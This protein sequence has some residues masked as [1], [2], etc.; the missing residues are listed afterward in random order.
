MADTTTI[1]KNP[2]L[3]SEED[4]AFLRSAGLQYIE[5]LGSALWTDY[6]EHDPGITILEALCYAITE[7]GYRAQLPMANLLTESNGQIASSQALFTAKNILTQAPL[8]IDDYRKLLIDIEG[9]HNAWLLTN[10]TKTNPDGT[11]STIAEVPFYA[12]CKEDKLT[13][14]TTPHPIFI[15]G[16]YTVLLDL[17]D[18]P[19]VGS[20]NNGE[21]EVLSPAIT[22]YN[23]G[24]VSFTVIFPAWNDTSIN[25]D[26][27]NA[28]KDAVSNVTATLT[29][30]GKDWKLDVSFSVTK[31]DDTTITYNATLSAE[32]VI[33]LQPSGRVVLLTDMQVFFSTQFTQQVIS[34][35]IYKLQQTK[36]IVQTAIKTLHENRNLCEDFIKVDT[37]P[38]EDIAI[39][40]DIDVTV[41]TDM[42]AVQADVWFA[43]EQYL[44]PSV[45]FYLLKDLLA[46]GYTPDEVF[47]GPRLAHGFIDTAE[48]ENTQL[49]TVIHASDVISLIMDI[50]GVLAVKNFRMTKYDANGKPVAN[51]TSKSWCMNITPGHKPVFY[52]TASKIL[53]YKNNFPCLP[54]LSEVRDTLKWLKAV[55]AA[56]KL[57]SHGDD[58]P[59]PIGQYNSIDEY[60]SI[61]ELFPQTYGIGSAGL[62]SDATEQ[63]KAQARQL[64]AYLLFYDQLLADFFSQLKNAKALFSTDSI[65]HTYFGQYIDSIKDVDAIYKQDSSH[66]SLLE[67]VFNNADSSVA[68]PNNWQNLYETNETFTDRRN[69][70]LDHLMARFDE[71]FNDYVLLMY[72]LDYETQQETKIDPKDLIN[73]K[74]D[75]IKNYPQTSYERAKA[76]NYFP[77]YGN[78]SATK[79]CDRYNCF[80]GHRQCFGLR[81]KGGKISRYFQC[82]PKVFVLFYPSRYCSNQRYTG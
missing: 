31:I 76:F 74:I 36:K 70:F 12:D 53:F 27:L 41:D 65:T 80:M 50:K 69:R 52:E 56:N 30:D 57:T 58:L 59:L 35:Y 13:Y 14:E 18:D 64:K 4:Y 34:L 15:S 6:N 7:L 71:S 38:D 43:I 72:S 77:Q 16:L 54:N 2:V 11:V 60:T 3:S 68:T 75:F 45:T 24:A 73:N 22:S 21:I 51:A 40:C 19:Q 17:D 78:R 10:D 48:L 33:E 81:K 5:E 32:I 66:N 9:V 61:D 63:R 23:A 47:E 79:F 25:T 26:L 62:P 55:H 42:D 29:Q 37:I 28:N 46:K 8:T 67:A 82:V 20:L 49:K 1:I 39:C 44:N